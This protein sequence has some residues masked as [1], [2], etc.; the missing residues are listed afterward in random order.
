M[1]GETLG[2][3]GGEV[4][5]AAGAASPEALER[6]EHLPQGIAPTLRVEDAE[7]ASL[8]VEAAPD[9]VGV[10]DAR[11]AVLVGGAG[12]VV[13]DV[14]R[15][16]DAVLVAR[17]VDVE[18]VAHLAA[19]KPRVDVP[20]AEPAVVVRLVGVATDVHG[21]ALPDVV[22]ELAQVHGGDEPL[23]EVLGVARLGVRVAVVAL[24]GGA[25]ILHH[26]GLEAGAENLDS[27]VR[28]A[29]R[30]SLIVD[31]AVQNLAD[32][33]LE[34]V[35]VRLRVEGIVVTADNHRRV[36]L[37]VVRGKLGRLAFSLR[38]RSAAGSAVALFAFLRSRRHR[39]EASRAWCGVPSRGPRTAKARSQVF[40]KWETHYFSRRAARRAQGSRRLSGAAGGKSNWSVVTRA[41][42]TGVSHRVPVSGVEGI[43]G[44]GAASCSFF[45]R[46]EV[47]PL[48]TTPT[49]DGRRSHT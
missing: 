14:V 16:S 25:L 39:R 19:A 23:H 10:G 45:C 24:V 31:L 34:V 8:V 42:G 15:A 37:V 36:S 41:I 48:V 13:V 46:N 4:A 22:H 9:G 32:Q 3:G 33:T 11:I 47:T 5:V 30:G 21:A 7:R 28:R 43:R 6:A 38:R 2:V 27:G 29:V 1:R 20:L 44:A 49:S 17:H 26:Q 40:A 12:S 35:L 18:G